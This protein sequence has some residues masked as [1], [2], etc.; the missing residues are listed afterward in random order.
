MLMPLSLHSQQQ[1]G[2][3]PATPS[4]SA[5]C[6]RRAA[7]MTV[8]LL[9]PKDI[10]DAPCLVNVD[11]NELCLYKYKYTQLNG[12]TTFLMKPLDGVNSW[13]GQLGRIGRWMQ[14]H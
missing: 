6:N 13:V 12:G 7:T 2:W 3:G 1:G 4:D 8:A 11:F 14:E 9:L 10:R 5:V